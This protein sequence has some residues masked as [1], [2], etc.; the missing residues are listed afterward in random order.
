MRLA[1]VHDYLNQMGGAELV[2]KVLHRV[3]PD[4]PIYTTIYEPS[5][6]D[7]EFKHMDIRTTFMQRL[8]FVHRHHQSFLPVFP[9]AIESMDL[10]EYNVVLSMSSAWSKNVLTRPET[11][12]ICYCLAPMR[13][14]WNFQDYAAGEKGIA[15]WQKPLLHPL[16]M[17]LRAWDVAGANRVDQ[18]IGISNTVN[19]RIKK[20]YRR[21]SALIHPPVDTTSYAAA[22]SDAS[23][24]GYFVIAARLVPYKRIDLAIQACNQLMLPL[25]IIG[26]GRDRERLEALAGPTIEFLG[27]VDDTT[28]RQL[29]RRCRAF[30]FPSEEDFG[31]A[32]VE[33]LASGRP[34]VAFAAGGALDLIQ[35]GVNGLFFW[36]QTP[37]ALA[38]VLKRVPEQ[39]WDSV[40][41]S[42]HAAKFDVQTFESKLRRFVDD[43]V[44]AHARADVPTV[45]RNETASLN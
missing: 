37:E 6:V 38:E 45:P 21:D 43:A 34:V 27:W 40:A 23:D 26:V 7:P 29:L 2:L 10:R 15:R 9:F 19:R 11:C 8:P 33:A 14:A 42:E 39:A 30:L 5:L 16:L 41:I 24:D 20:F 13:F 4:A 31:I 25:K 22:V 36:R 1:I 28:K 17:A 12:H 35:E 44:S 32:P 18:F 3:Y